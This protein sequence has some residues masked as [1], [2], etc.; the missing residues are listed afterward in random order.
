ME[1][2]KFITVLTVIYPSEMA[3]ARSRLES[4]G[5]TCF[6]KDE[7][8]TQIAPIYSNAIGGAQLQVKESDLKKAVEILKESGYLKEEDI[9]LPKELI[10]LNKI[11]SK[12]PLINKWL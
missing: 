11:L 8:M 6:I 4:E 10:R 1:P 3:I 7:L 5:I 12:I 9:Q 2:E